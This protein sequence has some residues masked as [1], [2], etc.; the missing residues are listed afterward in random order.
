LAAQNWIRN[1]T[2]GVSQE[3]QVRVSSALDYIVSSKGQYLSYV[4]DDMSGRWDALLAMESA[5]PQPHRFS[6][7]SVPGSY[8]IWFVCNFPQDAPCD[9]LLQQYGIVGVPGTPFGMNDSFTRLDFCIYDY[10]S[11]LTLSYLS[12]I[13]PT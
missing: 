3:A 1:I 4:R 10:L 5:Q 13:F 6:I 7:A 8:F 2:I 9:Q 11:A 12:K